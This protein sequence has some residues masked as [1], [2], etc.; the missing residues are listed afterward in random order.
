M[1]SHYASLP[2]IINY[3]GRISDPIYH[4]LPFSNAVMESMSHKLLFTLL[5]TEI[6]YIFR[7]LQSIQNQSAAL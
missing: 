6:L 3:S 1:L 4:A 2:L 5:K 7:I